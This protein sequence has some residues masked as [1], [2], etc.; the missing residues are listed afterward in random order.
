[1]TGRIDYT[2]EGSA[3][4]V[5]SRWTVYLAGAMFTYELLQS[6]TVGK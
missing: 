3:G 2:R 4:E 1:M 6:D 5:E